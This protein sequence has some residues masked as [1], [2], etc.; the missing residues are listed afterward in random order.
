M[1]PYYAIPLRGSLESSTV[2]SDF[3]EPFGKRT[4]SKSNF[5]DGSRNSS[6]MI[7]IRK[8]RSAIRFRRPG[9]F[10]RCGRERNFDNRNVGPKLQCGPSTFHNAGESMD[11]FLTNFPAMP[12]PNVSEISPICDSETSKLCS[13][14]ISSL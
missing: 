14:K 9:T 11:K 12:M 4:I 7:Q 3:N 2:I 5:K 10:G 8:K 6:R 13:Q 1:S